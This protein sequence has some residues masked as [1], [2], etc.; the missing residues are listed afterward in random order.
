MPFQSEPGEL[1]TLSQRSRNLPA[2]SDG[3]NAAPPSEARLRERK[4]EMATHERRAVE[5]V[6][7]IQPHIPEFG[8]VLPSQRHAHQRVHLIVLPAL[9]QDGGRQDDERVRLPG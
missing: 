4:D 5:T 2:S 6:A 3:D 7:A 8:L 1:R 9:G